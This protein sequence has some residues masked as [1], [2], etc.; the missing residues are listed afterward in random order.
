MSLAY[1]GKSKKRRSYLAAGG[2]AA[3]IAA[4]VA[5]LLMMIG[6]AF[7]HE[8]HYTAT[9]DCEGNWT[10]LA[11]YSGGQDTR[12][13]VLEG[14]TINGVAITA[15]QLN[16]AA[17]FTAFSST[18]GGSPFAAGQAPAG[19]AQ[20]Q[21]ITTFNGGDTMLTL[22]NIT[23]GP[24]FLPAGWSGNIHLYRLTAG[25]WTHVGASS[26]LGGVPN[27]VVVTAPIQPLDCATST[28]TATATATNTA[29]STAT[30]TATSTATP[31][32]TS[33]A[34]PTATSTAT[35]TATSTATA[36][37]TSTPTQTATPTATPTGTLTPTATPTNTQT[38]TATPTGT[39]T[40][41][42]T[43][44]VTNTPTPPPTATP[45]PP[46]LPAF[47]PTP[48][49]TP[50]LTQVSTPIVIVTNTPANTSTPTSVPTREAIN[51][52][53]PAPPR[54]GG[55]I[56]SDRGSTTVLMLVIGALLATLTGSGLIAAARKK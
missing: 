46:T 27:P 15:G 10:A 49:N 56:T 20:F 19:P 2:L 6:T 11:E 8:A 37:P 3:G 22:F 17:G 52:E 31:T 4:V 54:A 40:P 41:T 23:G 5:S 28:P 48:T 45:T 32:A 34:T 38:P 18:P 13:I 33:T 35:P 30:P 1:F 12:L 43:P 44:T 47:S 39:L 26:A 53:T 14:V 25:E 42:N 16:A 36:T 9:V 21:A 29:T 51:V 55:G 7:A 24:P 50:P